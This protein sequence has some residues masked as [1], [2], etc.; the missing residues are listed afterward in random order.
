M[1]EPTFLG[2]TKSQ[3][4]FANSFSNWLSAIG[5]LAAVWTSLYLANRSTMQKA[6][7]SV[8]HRLMIQPGMKGPIPEFVVFSI[9]NTG[10]RP[11]RVTH[12]GW[13]LGLWEKRQAMQMFD[14]GISSKLPVDL[15]HGQEASW[16][17]PLADREEPWPIYFAK[18]LLMPHHRI[19]LHTLR[20]QFFTSLGTRFIA[21]PEENLVSKLREACQELSKKSD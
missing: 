2:I 9:V 4:D 6:R 7:V 5:T 20:G 1:I 17:V 14:D 13:K 21:K 15:A 8:G 19:A 10:E 3:W 16:Y 12:I 18:G 11:M